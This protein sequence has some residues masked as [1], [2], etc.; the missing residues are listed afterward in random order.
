MGEEIKEK[1]KK[2]RWK[3]PE[4]MQSRNANELEG[5]SDEPTKYPDNEPPKYSCNIRPTLKLDK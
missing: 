3:I 1:K 5:M 2:Y 4:G